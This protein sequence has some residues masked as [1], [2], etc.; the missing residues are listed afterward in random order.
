MKSYC[1]KISFFNKHELLDTAI[2]KDTFT[3]EQLLVTASSRRATR[4][5]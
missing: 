5:Y 3:L 1:K 4:I 2:L